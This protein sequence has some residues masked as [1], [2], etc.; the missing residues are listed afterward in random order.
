[1][2]AR[3][4]TVGDNL[5]TELLEQFIRKNRE[6]VYNG[7]MSQ[8]Y[9]T[10]FGGG[11]LIWEHTYPPL[12]E[13]ARK[14]VKAGGTVIGIGL[15]VQGFFSVDKFDF[16]KS[17]KA[18]TVRNPQSAS[19]LY[20]LLNIK[21][22]VTQDLAWLYDPPRPEKDQNVVGVVI[23][24]ILAYPHVIEGLTKLRDYQ[25]KYIPFAHPAIPQYQQAQKKTGGRIVSS[26]TMQSV[27]SAV[28]EIAKC[29]YLIAG[30][31]HSM[32][33][34]FLTTTPCVVLPF[35]DK[36]RWMADLLDYKMFQALTA[37]EVVIKMKL[38]ARYEV[39]VKTHMVDMV[40]IAREKAQINLEVI[41]DFI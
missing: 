6:T 38:L 15:G 33:L 9:L 27:K 13:D 22:E 32:I 4:A 8:K 17:F 7:F 16:L 36:V 19:V 21:A 39:E 18:I 29:R 26:Q 35:R 3:G 28:E 30:H 37:D 11:G 23:P 10:I 14:A 31:L 40:R 2:T 41:K 34:A 24:S 12:L 20:D 5:I 1:L 25:L